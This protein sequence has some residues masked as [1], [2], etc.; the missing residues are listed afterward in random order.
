MKTIAT[1]ALAALAAAVLA[2]EAANP[3]VPAQ[4][5]KGLRG[6]RGNPAAGFVSRELSEGASL[7]FLDLR[8][9]PSDLGPAIERMPQA[10]GIAVE[11]VKAEKA[12]D[13][14]L[15]A[16]RKAL[17]SKEAGAA[18]AISNE[19]ADAPSLVVCPEDRMAVINADRLA[20]ASPEVFAK[21][22]TQEM[23]RAAAFVM[24]GYEVDYP[25]VMKTVTCVADLD[26]NPLQMTCPPVSGHVG[27]NAQK[28]GM[29]KVQCVPY[30]IALRQGWAPPPA[31]DAQREE[32]EKWEKAKAA[33]AAA[34]NAPAAKTAAPT[35]AK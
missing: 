1:I 19:G 27:A 7:R 2:Q 31:N 9:E 15:K 23:W 18:I 11:C 17:E 6:T 13:C 21:R 5:R 10:F 34:T 8:A 25:C 20:D 35:P 22:L 30:F 16:A 32:V 24:G 29:A 14:A 26:A 4:P 3:P 28:F 33:R 12:G